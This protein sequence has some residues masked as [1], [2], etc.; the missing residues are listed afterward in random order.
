M[1]T[2]RVEALEEIVKRIAKF[3]A[4]PRPSDRSEWIEK[5]LAIA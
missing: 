2:Q 1:H 5:I 4:G 3:K